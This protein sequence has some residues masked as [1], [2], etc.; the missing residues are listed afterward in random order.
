MAL[1][2]FDLAQRGLQRGAAATDQ[3]LIRGRYRGARAKGSA[4]ARARARACRAAV[5]AEGA[6][7]VLDLL[8][9]LLLWLPSRRCAHG[10][11]FERE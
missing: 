5:Q 10:L 11:H 7:L 4:R 1:P 6:E 9:L 3:L 8:L 2:V